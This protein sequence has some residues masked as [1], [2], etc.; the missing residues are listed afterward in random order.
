MKK[1]LS[2]LFVC[3]LAFIFVGCTV[4]GDTTTYSLSINDADKNITLEV[5]ESKAVAV[6]FEGGTLE[7]TTSDGT[8]VSVD[9][10][11]IKTLKAGSAV[12]TVSLKEK[13]DYKATISVTVT[14]KAPVVVEVTGLALAGK[15][16]TVEVGDTFNVNAV[17]TPTNATDK[18]VTWASSDATVAT[19]ENGKVTALKAGTTEISA[20]AGS[21]TEKF[22]LTV[23][24]KAPVVVDPEDIYLD[25]TYDTLKIGET[26]KLEWGIDPEEASQ[27]VEWTIT[28]ED[29]A[30][31]SED[32]TLT[33]LKGGVVTIKVSPVDHP[34]ISDSYELRIFDN[35]EGITI[36][37]QN[38]MQPGSTQT[39]KGEISHKRPDG[40]TINTMSEFKWESTDPEVATINDAGLVT[41][42]KEGTVVI[43]AIALD[44]GKY[45]AEFTINVASISVKIGETSYQNLEAAITAAK[46]NDIIDLGEG[47]ISK[48]I[49]VDKSGITLRGNGTVFAAHVQLADG[50]AN[51]KFV[52]IEF[53]EDAYVDTPQGEKA[54]PLPNAVGIT[55]LTFDGCK[56]SKVT[57][58]NDSSL[59]FFVPVTDFTF[60]NNQ[61]EF[62]TNRGIRFEAPTHNWLV[63]NN[64]FINTSAHY[65]T[66]RAMDLADGAITITNNLFDTC[67]QSL[68]QIRYI[69][70]GTY[71]VLFNTL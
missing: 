36:K 13:E 68:I 4:G 41:A 50:L 47:T 34:E 38:S 2:F 49:I 66:I 53:T 5:G 51:V 62:K 54:A 33:A 67:V 23:N 1:I 29:C 69:G 3:L 10:G 48:E 28:P 11:T 43:K 64:T 20:T 61:C 70:N 15:K 71:N 45:E 14:E 16:T 46:E 52:N 12:V 31:V 24:E 39:L 63:D 26:D 55:G 37:G 65:D 60:V 32:G 25:H 19:V 21:K 22:T 18:T 30:S 27:E 35:I 40:S 8:I 42:L 6:T 58:K 9:N 56:F 7:W 59:H 44:S 17:V 57:S